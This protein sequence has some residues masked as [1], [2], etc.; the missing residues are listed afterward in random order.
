[1][2]ISR[3]RTEKISKLE[4]EFEAELKQLGKDNTKGGKSS[5][6]FFPRS[7]VDRVT[8]DR[9]LYFFRSWLDAVQGLDFLSK[10]RSALVRGS[11]IAS[12]AWSGMVKRGHFVQ[13][14]V[15]ISNETLPRT[16]L[17]SQCELHTRFRF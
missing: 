15:D 16:L 10:D 1:M 2:M 9:S 4:Q 7:L 17:G 12:L 3:A 11:L 14:Y 13:K 8:V 5:N 6:Q